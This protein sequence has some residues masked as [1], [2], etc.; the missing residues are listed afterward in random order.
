MC[1]GRCAVFP[2][3]LTIV[4]NDIG[5]WVRPVDGALTSSADASRRLAS[6]SYSGHAR[7]A[8]PR[9]LACPEQ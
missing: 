1:R 4:Y 9:S 8:T 7:C 2:I 3:S 6:P 5:S